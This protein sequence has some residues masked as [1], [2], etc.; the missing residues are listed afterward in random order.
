MN[1]LRNKVQLIGRLGKDPEVKELES[2]RTVAKLS[3]ATTESYKNSE[4]EKTFDTQWHNLVAWGKVA[5][6]IGKYLKKGNEVAVE[7]RINNRSYEDKEGNIK[8]V[9]E[10]VVK[11]MMMLDKPGEKVTSDE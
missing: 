8:Y 5:E 4:G 9:N 11:E 2:G 7:G 6:I 1:K 10:I 3:L